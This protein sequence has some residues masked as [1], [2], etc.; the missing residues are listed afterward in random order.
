MIR[1]V[2]VFLQLK[3]ISLRIGSIDTSFG[4]SCE[5]IL[6]ILEELVKL[7]CKISKHIGKCCKTET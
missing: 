4:Y 3:L 1:G 2:N 7:L 5:E 6:K